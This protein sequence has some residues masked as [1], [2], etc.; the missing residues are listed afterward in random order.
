[1]RKTLLLSMSAAMLLVVSMPAVVRAQTD[2]V[3]DQTDTA[4]TTDADTTDS[5]AADRAAGRAARIDAYKTQVSDA[6]TAT[7]ER[8]IAAAC[9]AAQT[10][11]SRLQTNLEEAITKRTRVYNNVTEKLKTIVE[12]LQAASVDTNELETAI[13]EMERQIAA[14][15]DMVRTYQATLFDLAEMDCEAD[16]AGFKAALAVARQQRTEL[17][18]LAQTLREYI[19]VTIKDIL[20]RLRDSLA[21]DTTDS[22]VNT[23]GG[24]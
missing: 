8:R 7:E 21:S 16:P 1:M 6:I 23:S 22:S 12:R 15:L 3:N 10:V 20:Q 11:I 5:T 9:K 18:S 14:V 24:N 19:T 4:T 17:V 13:T 2:N